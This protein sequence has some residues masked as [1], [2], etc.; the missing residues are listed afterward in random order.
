MAVYDRIAHLS[1]L[2]GTPLF[3]AF[4]TEQQSSGGVF[5]KEILLSPDLL[6][7][8]I[9]ADHFFTGCCI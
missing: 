9:D 1:A 5:F 6:P 7:V 8:L 2:T 3:G 4:C